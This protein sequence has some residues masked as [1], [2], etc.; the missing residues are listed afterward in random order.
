[1]RIARSAWALGLALSA[2]AIAGPSGRA[3]RP[4]AKEQGSPAP[5]SFN[6]DILPILSNNCFACHGPDENK[7]ETKFHFDTHDGA[8]AKKGV[9]VPGNAAESFLVQRITNPDPD[10]RMPPA[11]TGHTLTPKQIDLLRRWIDEGAKWDTHWAYVPPKRPELP[12]V[13]QTTWVRNPIDQFILARLEREGLAPSPDAAKDVLLRRLT[14]DLTGL[15]PTPQET[16]AFLADSSPDAYEKQVD[17]LLVSPHYCE[18]MSMPWL[19][20]AR[21]ADT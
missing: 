19:D 11:E 18:R 15:P 6:R 17:R 7:R 21:Y 12:P 9:I 13:R 16:D 5:V 8:F 1:M 4:A 10:E 20:S 3:E 2:I 14:Y